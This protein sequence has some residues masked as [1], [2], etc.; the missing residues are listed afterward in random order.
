MVDVFLKIP[1][2]KC[3]KWSSLRVVLTVDNVSRIITVPGRGGQHI[4]DSLEA[5]LP[6]IDSDPFATMSKDANDELD[7]DTGD[8]FAGSDAPSLE[9]DAYAN[10]PSSTTAPDADPYYDGSGGDSP[11]TRLFAVGDR[12]TVFWPAD[13]I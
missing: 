3:G 13:N 6:S 4:Q 2:P 9:D 11:H 1:S 7:D 5:F 8:L 10:F 12:V